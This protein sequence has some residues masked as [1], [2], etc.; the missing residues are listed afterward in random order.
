MRRIKRIFGKCVYALVRHLPESYKVNI[1][2]K[3]FEGIL[4]KVLV[5]EMRT[6]CKYREKCR[7]CLFCGVGQ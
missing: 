6:K 7:I 5:G 1:G 4:R 2:Q 3:K